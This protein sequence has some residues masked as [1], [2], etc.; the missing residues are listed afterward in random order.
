MKNKT[1]IILMSLVLASLL[2][3]LIPWHNIVKKR[4]NLTRIAP[5]KISNF[6]IT[7]TKEWLVTSSGSSV[8]LNNEKNLVSISFIIIND[9]VSLNKFIE[10]LNSKSIKFTEKKYSVGG[11]TL[12][13]IESFDTIDKVVYNNIKIVSDGKVLITVSYPLE[14]NDYNAKIVESFLY[15]NIKVKKQ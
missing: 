8:N 1:K 6:Y 7:P 2:A 4:L 11:K 10:Y 14:G 13:G 3:V 9:K 15:N 5:I 12:D